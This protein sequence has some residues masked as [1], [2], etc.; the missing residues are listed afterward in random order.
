[1]A[2]KQTH[3]ETI[4]LHYKHT[5]FAFIGDK[6]ADGRFNIDHFFTWLES[7]PQKHRN[8]VCKVEV[9]VSKS[10]WVEVTSPEG[11]VK[12][13]RCYGACGY[14]DAM[15]RSVVE[16]AGIELGSCVLSITH[17]FP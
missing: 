11:E 13:F 5:G 3:Q 14:H 16:H 6:R 9:Y 15:V 8:L 1:M 4:E 12:R 10:C 2:C 17:Q 7:M